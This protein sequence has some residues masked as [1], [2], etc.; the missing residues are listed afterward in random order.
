ME[1][2]CVWRDVLSVGRYK[3]KKKER[4][5]MAGRNKTVIACTLAPA[6]ACKAYIYL[7][8]RIRGQWYRWVWRQIWQPEL[9]P[10][11]HPMESEKA[12]L[13]VI[14]CPPHVHTFT[15]TH[16]H[17]H[18]NKEKKKK[19]HSPGKNEWTK[20]FVTLVLTGVTIFIQGKNSLPSIWLEV[21]AVSQGGQKA[22]SPLPRQWVQFLSSE[23]THS[24]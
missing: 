11:T 8:I 14:L 5:V 9:V 2:W 4:K 6:P 21:M 22:G 7:F 19:N 1:V 16:M 20:P 17:T 23:V 24:Q 10:G 3:F 12:S 15:H 18:M 13:P